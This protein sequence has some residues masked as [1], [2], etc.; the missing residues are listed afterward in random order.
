MCVGN[1][2]V[3]L[4]HGTFTGNLE[5][6]KA[7]VFQSISRWLIIF[8][9]AFGETLLS[10]YNLGHNILERLSTDLVCHM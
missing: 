2:W 3:E 9:T 8:R 6:F 10:S 7:T 4:Y 5:I 1:K